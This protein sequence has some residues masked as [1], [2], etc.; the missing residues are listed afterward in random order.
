M[1]HAVEKRCKADRLQHRRK[2][3]QFEDFDIHCAK[4]RHKNESGLLCGGDPS[5]NDLQGG[6][7][8]RG[9]YVVQ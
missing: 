1:K 5:A 7:F 4:L 9:Q 3:T 8:D 2:T 6:D